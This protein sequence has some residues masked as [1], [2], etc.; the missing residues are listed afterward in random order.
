[1]SKVKVFIDGSEGTTGLRIYERLSGRA[2]VEL[3]HID[4]EKRKDPGARSEL[5]NAADA[6]FL[7]LPD[8]AAKESVSLLKSDKTKIIDASTAHRTAAGWAYGLPELSP[9]HREAVKTTR[10]IANPGCHATGVIVTAYPLITKGILSKDAYLC[11]HSVTGYSGGGKKMIAQYQD[12]NRPEGY[13]SPRQ[14]GLNL[15][16]K[17]LPEITHVLGLSNPPLFNPIVADFYAGMV[18]TLQLHASQLGGMTARQVHELFS[19]YYAGEKAVR[20]APFMGEGLLDDGT[21]PANT[22]AS[23][24][25]LELIICGN[26]RLTIVCARFDNLGKG[27]S[28]A[29]VQSMNLACGLDEYAGLVLD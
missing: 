16:H 19:E 1:M 25:Y 4:T 12:K 10:L 2:D 24:D 26:D 17:H 20:V 11:C 23:K 6:V 5:I 22:L 9:A 28:G 3:L 15:S 27:A 21:L 13:D 14:Y 7:C 18:T 8:D 29:A